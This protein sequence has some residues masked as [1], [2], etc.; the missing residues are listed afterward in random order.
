[1]E[2]PELWIET[3]VNLN[4]HTVTYFCALEHVANTLILIL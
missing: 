4:T 1:M 2:E 3:D